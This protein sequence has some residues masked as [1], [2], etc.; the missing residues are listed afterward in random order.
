MNSRLTR[1]ILLALALG[2]FVVWVLEFRRTTLFES[3]WLLL[4]SIVCLLFFQFSRL[5]ASLKAGKT[6]NSVS[7]P[8]KS[9]SAKTVK[10]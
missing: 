3:Y 2:F 7:N 9:K 5:K 1:T 8:V 4:L 10:K 6:E